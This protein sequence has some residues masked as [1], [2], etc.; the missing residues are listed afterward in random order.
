MRPALRLGDPGIHAACCGTNTWKADAGS[1]TVFINGKPAHRMNDRTQHCGG[2]GRLIEGSPNVIVDGGTS[3]GGGAGGASAGAGG[4]SGAGAGGAGAGAAGGRA[5]GAGAGAGGAGAGAG[6]AGAGAGAAGGGAGDGATDSAAGGDTGGSSGSQGLDSS[7]ANGQTAPNTN[8]ASTPISKDQIEVQIV[9]ALGHPQQSVDFDLEMP[10]GTAKSGSTAADG[11]LR[12]SGIETPGTAKLLLPDHDAMKGSAA[13]PRTRGAQL[14]RAGGVEVEVGQASI[15]ELQPRVYRG[16]LTGFLFDTDRT[17]VTP[18]ALEGIRL[19]TRMYEEHPGSEVLVSG[20]ADTV[21]DPAYNRGLSSERA[22]SVA[23]F[24]EDDVD[25]WLAWYRGKPS[26]HAWGTREDQYMLAT[27]KD[28]S[29]APFY[30]GPIGDGAG[31]QVIEAT[32]HYQQAR[33][34]VVDGVAGPQTRRALITD[35]M[36]TDGT[37]LPAG[38]VIQTH[39]CGESHPADPIGDNQNDPENRRVEVFFFEGPIDPAPVASCPIPSGCAEYDQWKAKTVQSLELRDEP[40]SIRITVFDE[41]DAAVDGASVHASGPTSANATTSAGSAHIKDIAAG[42]YV[43]VAK[44]EGFLDA[45]A[46][47]EAVA[48]GVSVQI[49]MLSAIDPAAFTFD[50]TVDGDDQP[51]TEDV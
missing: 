30:A 4:A 16:R 22:E 26:S 24:L 8:A 49:D 10:D 23:A 32:K 11:F 40:A 9:D 20:H 45:T 37:T 33:G 19:V 14:Y 34:L 41:N 3:S 38:T 48:G 7:D 36:A 50:V 5:G 27:V 43:L 1:M 25:T 39:G 44:K 47:V 29:G 18:G 28:D 17:F 21:G 6:G 42:H 51:P 35:Y 15:V 12:F 13:G 2:I 46:E 31:P